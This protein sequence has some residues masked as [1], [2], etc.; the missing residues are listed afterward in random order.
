LRATVE[1]ITTECDRISDRSERAKAHHHA[2]GGAVS[3]CSD[4][5]KSLPASVELTA[6]KPKAGKASDLAKLRAAITA[7]AEEI[8]L[9]RCA[10]LPASLLKKQA[11]EYVEAL[12][13]RGRPQIFNTCQAGFADEP[14]RFREIRAAPVGVNNWAR[15]YSNT[16]K[17]AG[18][19]SHSSAARP[20]KE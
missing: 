5:L 12:A 19:S 9:I 15:W 10:P 18:V 14:P 11:A 2:V 8:A 20:F 7:K 4:Y 6:I 16:V 1:R 3:R 17:A 13:A